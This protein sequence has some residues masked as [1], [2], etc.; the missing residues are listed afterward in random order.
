MNTQ[1]KIRA[2]GITLGV[3]VFVSIGLIVLTAAGP[4]TMSMKPGPFDSS[5]AAP[6]EQLGKAFAM[7]AAHVRPAV[8]SVY[9]EKLVKFR[10]PEFS[11]PFGEDF[12]RQFF[13]DQFPGQPRQPAQ[14]RQREY[15]IPQRGMGSGMIIDKEGRILTNF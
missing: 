8:V 4:H 9:S 13:G 1:N 14:P 7:V 10:Q 11:F 3:A 12:F 5:V 15:T 2:L 6:A